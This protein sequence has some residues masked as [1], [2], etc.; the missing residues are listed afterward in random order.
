MGRPPEGNELIEG[1]G[2]GYKSNATR[3]CIQVL[4]PHHTAMARMFAV[5]LQPGEVATLTGFTPSQISVIQGSPLFQAAVAKIQDM[6]DEGAVA[7][8]HDQLQGMAPRA[9]EVLDE[10]L[11]FMP[12][13]TADRKLRQTAAIDILNRTGYKIPER[14]EHAHAHILKDARDMPTAEL[15]TDVLDVINAD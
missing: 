6:L 13:C 4:K 12:L 3:G 14:V 8:V 10:D 9:A 11:N 2:G 7:E 1:Q 15:A 5:G